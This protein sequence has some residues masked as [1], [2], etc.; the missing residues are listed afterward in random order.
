MEELSYLVQGEGGLLSERRKGQK[1]IAIHPPHLL[2]VVHIVKVGPDIN[3]QF[4]PEAHLDIKPGRFTSRP[5]FIFSTSS[6]VVDA[7]TSVKIIDNERSICFDC[8]SCG[9]NH[10]YFFIIQKFTN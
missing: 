10:L 1:S 6:T 2:D 4:L 7:F 9:K 5:A 8:C 3:T